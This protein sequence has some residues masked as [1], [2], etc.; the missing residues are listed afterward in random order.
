[1]P[2]VLFALAIFEIGYYCSGWIECMG[3]QD[4]SAEELKFKVM[5]QAYK[6]VVNSSTSKITVVLVHSIL[7][8]C[9]C[10]PLLKE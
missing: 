2:S 4:H 3:V 6:V 8:D 10:F 9:S 7:C 1:M 5:Q